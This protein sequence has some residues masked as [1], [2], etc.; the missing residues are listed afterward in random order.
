[1]SQRTTAPGI[2][3]DARDD[4]T[5]APPPGTEC[6]PEVLEDLHALLVGLDR[7][8]ETLAEDVRELERCHGEDVYGE[9]I[10]LLSHLSFPASQARPHW[11]LIVQHR[12]SMQDRLGQKVD[13]R[14]ALVSYFVEVNR[15]LHNPK[16]IEMQLFERERASAYRDELTGLYNYRLFREHLTREVSQA[17]R[18]GQPVS[19][20]MLDVDDFKRYNDCNGHEAGN[21]ALAGVAKLLTSVLRKGDFAARYGGEEFA[22]IL[23]STPKT[24]AHLVAERTRA[25]VE[26]RHFV[27]EES[28]TEGRLTLSAG[29]ATFPADAVDAAE[30]IRHADRALYVAK[31]RGKNQVSLYGQSRRSFGRLSLTVPGT[32]RILADESHTLTTVNLSEAGL[33]FRTDMEMRVGTI[34]ELNVQTDPDRQITATGRVVHVEN[35]GDGTFRTAAHITDASNADRAH[36]MNLIR[37]SGTKEFAIVEPPDLDLEP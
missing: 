22:L 13:L 35:G 14:V 26:Q 6:R 8:P 29:I 37:D 28:L 18:F 19:L 4:E 10:Y 2:V 5:I 25:S 16:I 17:N 24:N 20:V 23:P 30:L 32:F 27:G 12:A 34:L 1:M 9:L 33:L 3:A 15:Q 11:Q 21:L 36:L 7:E 31:A